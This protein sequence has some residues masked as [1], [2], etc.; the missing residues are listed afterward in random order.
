MK[1]EELARSRIGLVCGFRNLWEVLSWEFAIG[2]RR[3][4]AGW[5]EF[6]AF[7]AFLADFGF[8]RA[9]CEKRAGGR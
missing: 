3:S 7:Y 2:E 4:E 5:P 1:K 8:W 6:A 9:S